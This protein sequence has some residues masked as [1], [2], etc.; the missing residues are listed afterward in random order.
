MR[1]TTQQDRSSRESAYISSARFLD[2]R[3]SLRLPTGGTAA[4]TARRSASG[5]GSKHGQYPIHIVIVIDY[6]PGQERDREAVAIEQDMVLQH[7]IRTQLVVYFGAVSI[8]IF[9]ANSTSQQTE[10]FTI[11]NQDLLLPTNSRY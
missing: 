5:S 3:C 7:S 4:E 2:Y 8:F 1:D 11:K 6:S 10:S 9:W